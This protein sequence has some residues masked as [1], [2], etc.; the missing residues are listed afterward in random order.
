MRQPF[1]TVEGRVYVLGDAELQTFVFADSATAAEQALA[2]DS[3]RVS[4][5][6]MAISWRRKPTLIR[7]SNLVAILLS[8]DERQTERV[9][10]AIGA[11]LPSAP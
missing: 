7:S 8:D 1:F 2:L 6:T 9:S 4:P 3:V 11:G 10:L 5:P